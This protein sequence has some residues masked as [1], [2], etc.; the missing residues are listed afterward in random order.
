M[1][2]TVNAK[3]ENLITF[4]WIFLNLFGSIDDDFNCFYYV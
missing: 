4:L 1:R 3:A 2:M